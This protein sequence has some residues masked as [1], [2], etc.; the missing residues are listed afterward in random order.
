MIHDESSNR[1]QDQGEDLHD[2]KDLTEVARHLSARTGKEGA[3]IES[4]S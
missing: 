1:G 4:A 3:N 2:P